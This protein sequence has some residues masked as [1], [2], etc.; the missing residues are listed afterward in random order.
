M[1][2]KRE[3]IRMNMI[4]DDNSFNYHILYLN[5]TNQHW[6]PSQGF[7][8]GDNLLTAID[9]GWKYDE[10]VIRKTHS[11]G[12]QRSTSI[13]IFTLH[14]DGDSIEMPVVSTPFI[15]RFIARQKLDIIDKS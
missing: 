10:N 1:I 11:F 5:V 3:G 2:K 4:L 9:Q 14:R 12:E 15:R 13:Y 6:H 8:R 7:A